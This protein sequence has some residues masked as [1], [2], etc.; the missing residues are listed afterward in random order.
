MCDH[1]RCCE[2]WASGWS[3][4]WEAQGRN[5]I[6]EW[7]LQP[8]GLDP[9]YST[10]GPGQ[11]SAFLQGVGDQGKRMTNKTDTWTKAERERY[12]MIF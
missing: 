6:E 4:V 2:G 9:G 8:W 7:N 10:P 12:W 3:P 1:T 5:V 11:Q